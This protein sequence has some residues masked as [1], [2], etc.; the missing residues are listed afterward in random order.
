MSARRVTPA[1]FSRM[2]IWPNCCSA[3]RTMRSICCRSP[4]SACTAS[5]RRCRDMMASA[6]A[7][8]FCAVDVGDDDVRARLGQRERRGLADALAGAGD[9]GDLIGQAH[10]AFPPCDRA[11]SSVDRA[12]RP[13]CRRRPP[14]AALCRRVAD[15]RGTGMLPIQRRV[16]QRDLR[17][18]QRFQPADGRFGRERI[19]GGKEE[20]LETG[21]LN[22][23]RGSE[24]AGAV[25][26]PDIGAQIGH[27]F[28]AALPVRDCPP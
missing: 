11:Q 12:C 3:S 5:A 18:V 7:S 1:L 24:A 15:R 10:A 21:I 27:R 17:P 13:A 23:R 25:L 22:R 26:R 8:A 28:A 20:C 19:I 14:E 9:Q 6:V 2:S 4:T 16:A